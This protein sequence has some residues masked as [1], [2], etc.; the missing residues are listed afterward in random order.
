MGSTI[1]TS[2]LTSG[3][4]GG[5]QVQEF[6]PTGGTSNSTDWAFIG[7]LVMVLAIIGG[8]VYFVLQNKGK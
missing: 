2:V 6:S 4:G 8:V 5:G 1:L 7:I 3:F